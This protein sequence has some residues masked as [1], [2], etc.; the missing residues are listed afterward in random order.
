MGLKNF[1]VDQREFNSEGNGV[2]SNN[3]NNDSQM[4]ISESTTND[5][6]DRAVRQLLEPTKDPEVYWSAPRMKDGL[7]QVYGN[8]FDSPHLVIM[9]SAIPGT[10]LGRLDPIAVGK[11]V[12]NF[13]EGP[14]KIYISGLN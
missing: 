2:G 9:E 4:N 6:G 1:G 11:F 10:N 13:V 3:N 12:A 7:P 8:S 14:R 5:N